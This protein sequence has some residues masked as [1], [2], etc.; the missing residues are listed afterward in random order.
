MEKNRDDTRER[1]E[2]IKWTRIEDE[3]LLN[4]VVSRWA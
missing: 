1:F 2:K 3:K 4:L